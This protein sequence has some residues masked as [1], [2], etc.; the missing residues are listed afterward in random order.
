M[1]LR[2]MQKKFRKARHEWR[3]ICG[4]SCR[5]AYSGWYSCRRTLAKVKRKPSLIRPLG[6]QALQRVSQAQNNRKTTPPLG[7]TDDGPL[8]RHC[9]PEVLVG[10]NLRPRGLPMEAHK[11]H[12]ECDVGNNQ[13]A[14]KHHCQFKQRH[15]PPCAAGRK[16]IRQRYMACPKY[17][18]LRDKSPNRDKENAKEVTRQRNEREM[19]KRGGVVAR[20]KQKGQ[21]PYV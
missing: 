3:E 4:C 15:P 19:A 2:G 8:T 12:A 1:H 21:R 16:I 9:H 6:E 20:T 10:Y 18:A 17:I 11:E 14:E 7:D 5:M 13:T